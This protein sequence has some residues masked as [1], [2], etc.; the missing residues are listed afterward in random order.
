MNRKLKK[1]W[2]TITTLVVALVM[3][4]GLGFVG[5][6]QGWI[7]FAS[8][9][10]LADQWGREIDGDMVVKYAKE[11]KEYC[12]KQTNGA[13]DYTWGGVSAYYN[14]GQVDTIHG[15]GVHPGFD[16]SG[17]VTA[18]YMR[19]AGYTDNINEDGSPKPNNANY[20]YYK[21]PY[22][23]LVGASTPLTYIGWNQG[24]GDLGTF[25]WNEML[26]NW[27]ITDSGNLAM[28]QEHDLSNYLPGD[29][30]TFRDNGGSI[31]HMG[32][33]LGN[34]EVIH[35]TPNMS[36]GDGIVVTKLSE[37][38]KSPGYGSK[39][40]VNYRISETVTRKPKKAH[41]T[42]VKKDSKSGL[43][44]GQNG[45]TLAG[46]Q[47]E[48]KNANGELIHTFT[49]GADGKSDTA[50]ELELGT[51]TL[52]E[53]VAPSGYAKDEK[54]YTI[55]LTKENAGQT[56]T[57]EVADDPLLG[58]AVIHK[59]IA[60][61]DGENSPDK[62]EKEEGAVFAIIAD[63]YVTGLGITPHEAYKRIQSG[64]LQV[65]PNEYSSATTDANGYAEFKDLYYGKY[66]LI[67]V[68]APKTTHVTNEIFD[69]NVTENTLQT[70]YTVF[71]EPVTNLSFSKLDIA[72][73]ELAGAKMQIFVDTGEVDEEGKPL[74]AEGAR[75]VYEWTSEETPHIITDIKPGKYIL[76]EDLAP[77]GYTKA[78]N[79]Q[80]VVA[81]NYTSQKV[82]MIDK[83][84]TITKKDVGGD[85]VE[86]AKMTVTD[87]EGNIVDEWISTK[88]PHNV[89]NLEEGKSYVIHEEVAPKGYVIATDIPF[90]VSYDKVTEP[91]EVIDKRLAVTKIAQ[92]GKHERRLKGAKLQ[93]LDKDKQVVDEWYT[94][95]DEDHY[96]ENLVAGETYALHE[97]IAPIG[98]IK[99]EDIEF[100]VEDNATD[101]TVKMID[102]D[103][104]IHKVDDFNKRVGGAGMAIFDAKGNQVDS[105]TTYTK[106]ADFTE[107]QVAELKKGETVILDRGVVITDET[108]KE[109][110]GYLASL[111]EIGQKMSTPTEEGADS[112][113][114]TLEFGAVR[115]GLEELFAKNT[116]P[117]ETDKKEEAD[118]TKDV[119]KD[120]AD[121]DTDTDEAKPTDESEEEKTNLMQNYMN[122]LEEL[123][124]KMSKCE[125]VEDA[126]TVY[127]TEYSPLLD[128]ISDNYVKAVQTETGNFDEVK[129]I[130]SLTDDKSY[131]YDLVTTK[132]DADG[133]PVV[134]YTCVDLNGFEYAHRARNLEAGVNYTIKEV[135]TPQGYANAR[136]VPF[137]ADSE[138]TTLTVSMVDSILLV[139]S[140]PG[141][142]IGLSVRHVFIAG[143]VVLIGGTIWGISALVKR[144]SKKKRNH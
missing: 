80:F 8:G 18:V 133:N 55:E 109:L 106:V 112:Y 85:E 95:D 13:Q 90:T 137:I 49:I 65:G 31:T 22:G 20:Q 6:Q 140:G 78:S 77:I 114:Y 121:T 107:E 37:I 92:N 138:L 44:Y 36:Y 132:T 9:H 41:I 119:A 123:L 83:V 17:F 134:E 120:E 94:E 46:A 142:G 68:S 98:Y 75:P 42:V 96:V 104:L 130:A 52:K 129:V 4:I 64:A 11:Y 34:G 88:E 135:K 73:Q 1:Y 66:K 2:K 27:N 99:A 71:N 58:K 116:A 141:T 38:R 56:V 84:V 7:S 45:A 124:S 25:G 43:T 81:K 35:S 23:N 54:E 47:Y 105:W 51:Y 93:V 62:C 3:T 89:S 110:Q 40:Y 91:Y 76:H 102:P 128:V 103:L 70:E 21:D 53:T 33:Y 100:T 115:S 74:I 63:K 19:V 10:T 15:T 126:G 86:G 16:C 67:Q 69:V 101:Q 60:S 111:T 30:V 82:E 50:S 127:N 125:T 28:E 79:V 29:I 117:A 143:G 14:A 48:L 5:V 87:E 118:T 32:I 39:H 144:H 108:Q 136:E 72:G 122:K 97:E 131:R 61:E 24:Y 139:S 113:D 12:D 59:Y 57:R 26:E